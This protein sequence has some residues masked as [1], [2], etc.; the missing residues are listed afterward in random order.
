MTRDDLFNI[1][2][3]IARDLTLA[4]AEVAPKALIAIIT[5][6][7][8]SLVPIACEVLKKVAYSN[9]DVYHFSLNAVFVTCRLMCTTQ[10]EFSEL[11][12]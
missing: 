8:N 3:G 4:A 1:N 11:Q 2:A 10:K 7:V 12:H 5:N 9:K 6:P